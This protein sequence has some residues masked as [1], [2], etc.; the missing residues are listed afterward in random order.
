M[1]IGLILELRGI[2]ITASLF[3]PFQFTTFLRRI[4]PRLARAAMPGYFNPERVLSVE[5]KDAI[6]LK[7]R[8]LREKGEAAYI[9]AGLGLLFVGIFLQIIAA[10]VMVIVEFAPESH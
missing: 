1:V 2:Y 5:L 4:M 6:A 8:I 7:V 10:A 3:Q 9:V